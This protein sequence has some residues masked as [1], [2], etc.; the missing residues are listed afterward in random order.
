[1]SGRKRRPGVVLFEV[2]PVMLGG[3]PGDPAN[4]VW[5]TL[6]QHF[7]AVRYWNKVIGQVRA[8]QRK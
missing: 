1:M 4:K 3:D 6:E 2:K 8:T 5:L 7:K